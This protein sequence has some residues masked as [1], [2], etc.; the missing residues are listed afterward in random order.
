MTWIVNIRLANF[1]WFFAFSNNFSQKLENF[2]FQNKIKQFIIQIF[3]NNGTNVWFLCLSIWTFCSSHT[4]THTHSF[5]LSFVSLVWSLAIYLSGN[6][7]LLYLNAFNWRLFFLFNVLFC[8]FFLFIFR[9]C[10]N[11]S[12]NASKQFKNG[13]SLRREKVLMKNTNK[14]LGRRGFRTTVF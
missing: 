4:Y 10:I 8:Y 3:E 14:K 11:S 2:H 6:I 9:W 13:D 1:D 12:L 5:T 7:H